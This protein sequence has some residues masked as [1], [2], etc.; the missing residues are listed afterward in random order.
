MCSSGL[1]GV[2]GMFEQVNTLDMRM[3]CKQ[4]CVDA[5]ITLFYY[6]EFNTDYSSLAGSVQDAWHQS[7]NYDVTVCFHSISSILV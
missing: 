5:T 7:S 4:C 1:E 2:S 3:T 6:N